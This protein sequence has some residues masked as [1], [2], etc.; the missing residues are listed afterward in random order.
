MLQYIVIG[1]MFILAIVYL[2]W[3]FIRTFSSRLYCQKACGCGK[4]NVDVKDD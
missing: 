2:I 1:I 3:L 4:G